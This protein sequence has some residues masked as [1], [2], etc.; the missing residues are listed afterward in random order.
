MPNDVNPALLNLGE[1]AEALFGKPSDNNK[2]KVKRLVSHGEIE[3]ITVSGK[4]NTL[5]VPL[6]VVKEWRG[7]D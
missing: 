5:Y 1:A 4:R 3:A 7:D 2:R 6:S